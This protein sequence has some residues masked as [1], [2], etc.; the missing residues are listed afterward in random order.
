MKV[1]QARP[2]SRCVLDQSLLVLGATILAAGLGAMTLAPGLSA[3]S[4][5]RE[6]PLIAGDPR[7]DNTDVYAFTSPDKSDTVTMVAN[8]I[9]MEEPNGGPNFYAFGDDLRYNIKIDNT[10]DGVADVT[11]SWR[12]RNSY[13]DDAN[14]FLYN[15]GQ[16][17]SLNDPDLNFRQVYDLVV[18]TGGKSRTLLSGVPA[19]PSR[20][21]KASMPDYAALRKQATFGLPGGGTTYTGQA[22]DPFFADLRVFDLLYGGDLSERG[23]DTLAGYNVNT[24]A[25][26]VPKKQLALKG[27]SSRNPVIG[28]WSTTDRAGVT[29]TDSRNTERKAGAK[30][31]KQVSRLGNPLVN[32]VVVPLKFK[33]AFNTLNP[34]QDRTVQPVVDKVYDPILPKLIQQVY[35]IPAPKTPRNDLAEIYL[36]GICKVCG[37]IKADLNAHRLNKDAP[38]RKIVPAEELRLNMAVPP[39]AKPQRLGVL[40]G[41]LAGFPNGRRL[42]DDVIDISLQAVEGAAQTGVLVPA[43]AD[44]DKVDTNEVPFDSS[45]PY[46]ALPHTKNVNRGPG[47]AGRTAEQTSAEN[48]SASPMR[49]TTQAAAFT[50][51]GVMLLG[52]GG[53]RLHRRGKNS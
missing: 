44:G 8:W 5:H 10:G 13:R 36:T 24:I 12:F 45:F 35:G 51:V 7:A 33:D 20:T 50:G 22:E 19:A 41:D 21:G 26:Q 37:P 46:V 4:S 30:Q 42:A 31:W 43:L 3:A 27:N 23:Q 49:K 32:E 25:I 2:R 39:T 38:L 15:T 40:A 6:A 53:F 18:T 29:V 28:V 14:Q 9:P 47:A 1:S 11:Y 17:T 34:S 48:T 52:I 16:V